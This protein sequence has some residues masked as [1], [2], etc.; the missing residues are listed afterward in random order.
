MSTKQDYK[1]TQQEWDKAIGWGKVPEDREDKPE[2][3]KIIYSNLWEK[4][5]E[6]V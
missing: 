3:P 4:P 5:K 6:N 1:Y 2:E